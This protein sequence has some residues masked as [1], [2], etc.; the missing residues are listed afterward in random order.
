MV[1]ARICTSWFKLARGLWEK[2]DL[3][4]KLHLR[5]MEADNLLAP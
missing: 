2:D 1:L 5:K 4:L 3:P